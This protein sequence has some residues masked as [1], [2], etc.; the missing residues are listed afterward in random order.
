MTLSFAKDYYEARTGRRLLGGEMLTGSERS[1]AMVG[2]VLAMAPVVGPSYKA[3]AA[4]SESLAIFAEVSKAAKVE[5][6]A[7]SA[8]AGELAG[9]DEAVNGASRVLDGANEIGWGA[10]DLERFAKSASDV[11]RHGPMSAGRMHEIPVGNGTLADTF[12]SSSYFSYKN[13]GSLTL[14]RVQGKSFE[15]GDRLG[16]FWTRD[17][18]SGPIQ[19]IIDSALDPTWG[20]TGTHWVK[21]EVP[22]GTSLY[23]GVA[24]S[25]RGLVG[26]GN[27]IVV[28]HIPNTWLK[29]QGKF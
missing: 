18:P 9:L 12:R 22:P 10:G 20:N 6:R 25:Q 11:S 1:M 15:N 2:A 8:V 5:A 29:E 7:G 21:I 26:G 4:A 17:K 14:Y 24:A 3:L 16:R 27:Q 13:T 19:S 23:E 28:E